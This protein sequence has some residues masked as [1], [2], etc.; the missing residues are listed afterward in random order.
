MEDSILSIEQM[1]LNISQ[2]STVNNMPLTPRNNIVVS[3][4]VQPSSTPVGYMAADQDE[5]WLVD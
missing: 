3:T 5:T 1:L 2:T 4:P